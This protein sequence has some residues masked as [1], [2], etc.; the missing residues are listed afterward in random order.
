MTVSVRALEES[1]LGPVVDSGL[2]ETVPMLTP[3]FEAR[4]WRIATQIVRLAPTRLTLLE[5][6]FA[7]GFYILHSVVPRDASSPR[8]AY[9]HRLV[10]VNRH[11]TSLRKP[12]EDFPPELVEAAR[13]LT[14]L[15]DPAPALY[16]RLAGELGLPD[17]R[18]L[19]PS[20]AETLSLRFAV[21]WLQLHSTL[22]RSYACWQGVDAWS[23]VRDSFFGAFPHPEL[24]S[25]AAERVVDSS[26]WHPEYRFWF[27]AEGAER[28]DPPVACVGSDGIVRTPDGAVFDIAKTHRKSGRDIWAPVAAV[29]AHL[30]S[31]GLVSPP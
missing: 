6:E 15:F 2:D 14:L 25:L 10:D 4:A 1:D 18:P 20:T 3:F 31:I 26:R 13:E 5:S 7:D 29:R 27:I 12:G 11:G 22:G 9:Q 17:P 21:A 19:P 23:R 16:R 8:E 28:R 30:E 24:A